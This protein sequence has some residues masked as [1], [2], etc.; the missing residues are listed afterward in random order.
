MPSLLKIRLKYD[1]ALNY[2]FRDK[3]IFLKKAE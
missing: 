2:K 1:I 3:I